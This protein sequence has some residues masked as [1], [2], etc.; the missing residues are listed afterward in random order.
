MAI[1]KCINCNRDISDKSNE[2]IHCGYIFFKEKTNICS[3]CGNIIEKGEV[4]CGKCGCP[5]FV[6]HKF[7][8]KAIIGAIIVVLAIIGVVFGGIKVNKMHEQK[9]AMEVSEQYEKN[10]FD[11]TSKMIEGAADAEKCGN[12]ILRVWDNS[13]LRKS[14]LETD[15][16]TK[17]NG[18]FND[19]FNYSLNALTS[20]SDFVSI[21]DGIRDNNHEVNVLMKNMKN[22]PKEW[23]D[24]YKD[25]M[26]CYERYVAY[27]ELAEYPKGSYNSYSENFGKAGDDLSNAYA[28]MRLHLGY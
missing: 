19:D 28:K 18:I 5:I 25:L 8:K 14:D 10:L 26:N 16:Y 15:K 9:V 1:V 23:E 3:E 6:K 7:N 20:D 13:I 12:K 21:I 11:I 4:R 24:V 2:C 27:I 17:T 22:P